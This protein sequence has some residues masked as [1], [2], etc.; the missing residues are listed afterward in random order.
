MPKHL[1]MLNSLRVKMVQHRYHAKLIN[2][3]SR[4]YL[5]G[6]KDEEARKGQKSED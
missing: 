1:R 3:V 5:Q 6:L 4:I 2:L